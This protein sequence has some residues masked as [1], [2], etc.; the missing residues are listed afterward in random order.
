MNNFT[1]SS[2]IFRIPAEVLGY[3]P[4]L[5]IFIIV[6]TREMYEENLVNLIFFDSNCKQNE[7]KT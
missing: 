2:K 4:N 6:Y 3:F 1:R 5:V 7:I